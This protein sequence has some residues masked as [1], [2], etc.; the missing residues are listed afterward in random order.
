MPDQKVMD[1]LVQYNQGLELYKQK[2]FEE[3]KAVFQKALAIIPNDGP[4][5]LYFERCGLL[6]QSPPPPDWDGVFTMT[7]K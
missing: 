2:K 6:I 7:T 5:Q 4:S 3:A 1:M